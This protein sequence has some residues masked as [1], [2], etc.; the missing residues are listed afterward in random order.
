[1]K[2]VGLTGGIATGKSTVSEMFRQRGAHIIDADLVSRDVV[3]PGKR[4]WKKVVRVFGA[5]VLSDS[6]EIDRD[7]LGR[8]VF[9][10]GQ[11]RMKLNR[12]THPY[13]SMAIL[14][15]I[16]RHF[17][18]GVRLV[19]LDA[20]LLLETQTRLFARTV[21]VVYTDSET[22]VRRLVARNAY[23]REEAMQRI[24]AQMPL[25][26]KCRVATYVIDN[27]ASIAHT[28]E[29]VDRIWRELSR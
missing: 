14:G 1:M 2:I 13:I 23:S 25:E 16:L 22:Q 12:A 4:A 7:K 20:A 11:A 29:Q 26:E 8:I 21:I 10:D 18:R 24:S 9:Q 3:K 5:A 27:S 17:L 28:Q 6:G 19:I 15:Q